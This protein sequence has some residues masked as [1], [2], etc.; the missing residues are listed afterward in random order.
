MSETASDNL[1]GF[2]ASDAWTNMNPEERVSFDYNQS[3]EDL[4]NGDPEYL[5][6]FLNADTDE[7]ER[8]IDVVTEQ[9]KA[10][11]PAAYAT[12]QG[13][14]ELEAEE[15]EALEEEDTGPYAE[16]E[17]LV[18]PD[19]NWAD[20]DEQFRLRRETEA[21]QPV[22]NRFNFD[23]LE[24]VKNGIRVSKRAMSFA[25]PSQPQADGKGYLPESDQRAVHN[26][27]SDKYSWEQIHNA[28]TLDVQEGDPTRADLRKELSAIQPELQE[29]KG[30]FKEYQ[31][32]TNPQEKAY[33]DH[34]RDRFNVPRAPIEDALKEVNHAIS[35]ARNNTGRT[36]KMGDRSP[37]AGFRDVAP[38]TVGESQNEALIKRYG[39]DTP[40]DEVKGELQKYLRILDLQQE[41]KLDSYN[42]ATG[43]REAPVEAFKRADKDLLN[44]L[45][46]IR[47]VRDFPET[48]RV[49]RIL[50]KDFAHIKEFGESNL[51][52]EEESLLMAYLNS[53]EAEQLG[54]HALV[55][56]A[57]IV[58]EMIPYALEFMIAGGMLTGTKAAV[59]KLGFRQAQKKARA[60]IIQ[61]MGED[62]NAALIRTQLRGAAAH[63][64]DDA[65]RA[66]YATMLGAQT[67]LERT[68][69][70]RI[71]LRNIRVEADSA[72]GRL[73]R[74]YTDDEEV[75]DKE[76]GNVWEEFG[77]MWLENFSE[78]GS[79]RLAG[80]AGNFRTQRGIKKAA[81]GRLR[82]EGVS[83]SKTQ[84]VL[85]GFRKRMDQSPMSAKLRGVGKFAAFVAF[86]RGDSALA[87]TMRKAGLGGMV[88][89]Y[90]EESE[91]QMY[92]TLTNLGVGKD[93]K[94]R[95]SIAAKMMDWRYTL[96]PTDGGD[97]TEHL[98]LLGA[99]AVPGAMGAAPG[100]VREIRRDTVKAKEERDIARGKKEIEKAKKRTGSE[101]AG[102]FEAIETAE[103]KE[104]KQL[105]FIEK[106]LKAPLKAAQRKI[107][108]YRKELKTLDKALETK[109]PKGA[110]DT[111]RQQLR[112]VALKRRS[113]ASRALAKAVFDARQA[114]AKADADMKE[115]S[116]DYRKVSDRLYAGLGKMSRKRSQLKN[117]LWYTDR[118]THDAGYDIFVKHLHQVRTVEDVAK[119]ARDLYPLL[120]YGASNPRRMRRASAK[121]MGRLA[122]GLGAMKQGLFGRGDFFHIS[123]IM[124]QTLRDG[125]FSP[126]SFSEMVR[127]AQTA[128]AKV[129]RDR[130]N[131]KVSEDALEELIA[132]AVSKDVGK[133]ITE[134]VIPLLETETR[135]E[136]EAVKANLQD[137]QAGKQITVGG[138]PLKGKLLIKKE[139][140]EKLDPEIQKLVARY[141]IAVD[142]LDSDADV[143]DQSVEYS[144]GRVE[145]EMTDA[146]A[147]AKL[148]EILTELLPEKRLKSMI[149]EIIAYR[150]AHTTL[151][152]SEEKEGEVVERAP[153]ID[154]TPGLFFNVKDQK[155]LKE[156]AGLKGNLIERALLPFAMHKPNGDL[157]VTLGANTADIK[158]EH[159]EQV[160][161]ANGM[162][163]DSIEDAKLLLK[164]F[165]RTLRT[166]SKMLEASD[167]KHITVPDS[168][169][170]FLNPD[171][172]RIEV[173]SILQS[174][175]LILESE[176]AE[177]T[178]LKFFMEFLSSVFTIMMMSKTGDQ[179][180][181][182]RKDLDEYLE[183][184]RNMAAFEVMSVLLKHPL[185]SASFQQLLHSASVKFFPETAWSKMMPPGWKAPD[186][187]TVK[188]L[189]GRSFS[190]EAIEQWEKYM[191]LYD[192]PD[193]EVGMALELLEG[194]PVQVAEEPD[195]E[196]EEKAMEAAAKEA[197]VD[198][199]G[200]DALMT[201]EYM[202]N[203]RLTDSSFTVPPGGS[204]KKGHLA[205]L[206]RSIDSD[207]VKE[208][209]NR[210][211][212]EALIAK[213]E[214]EEKA[215]DAEEIVG[216]GKPVRK[217]RKAHRR[218]KISQ[219]FARVTKLFPSLDGSFS[220][221]G[222]AYAASPLDLLKIINTTEGVETAD[223]AS[224][225]PVERDRAIP[226]AWK[227]TN[228]DLKRKGGVFGATIRTS[229]LWMA[230]QFIAGNRYLGT[231]LRYSDEFAKLFGYEELETLDL[232]L[233]RLQVLRKVSQDL[234]DSMPKELQALGIRQYKDFEKQ[235]TQSGE[236]GPTFG[237]E[238]EEAPLEDLNIEGVDTDA[239]SGDID[240]G[241]LA[242]LDLDTL[243]S[244]AAAGLTD[245][246]R[247]TV[248]KIK[249]V[250]RAYA[251]GFL[252]K[253]YSDESL[254][255]KQ[256]EEMVRGYITQLRSKLP[257]DKIRAI[258]EVGF[259]ELFGWTLK[260]PTRDVH[261]K[262]AMRYVVNEVKVFAYE[263]GI[264]NSVDAED[265]RADEETAQVDEETNRTREAAVMLE[266]NE[267]WMTET[268]ALL[269]NFK[270]KKHVA[271]PM[272]L[273]AINS[274]TQI[275]VLFKAAREI[276][277][278]HLEAGT[279]G[280][281]AMEKE[282]DAEFGRYMRSPKL[283]KAEEF[284]IRE[285]R[286]H[287][288]R[289][290]AFSFSD[291]LDLYNRFNGVEARPIGWMDFVRSSSYDFD[292]QSGERTQ[293]WGDP[294]VEATA[295]SAKM[296]M[297]MVR[298][299][300]TIL[301]DALSTKDSARDFLSLIVEIDKT[302]D[303]GADYQTSVYAFWS[304]LLGVPADILE[305]ADL[306]EQNRRSKRKKAPVSPL[307]WIL[308]RA[309]ST[310]KEKG[311]RE[312][313]KEIG[314]TAI[315][316][317]ALNQLEEVETADL[318][319]WLQRLYLDFTA[320]G[321]VSERTNR[322]NGISTIEQISN[323]MPVSQNPLEIRGARGQRIPNL[324]PMNAFYRAIGKAREA[325][326]AQNPNSMLWDSLQIE[327][328]REMRRAGRSLSGFK[329]KAVEP[330]DVHP[331]DF[332]RGVY[333]FWLSQEGQGFYRV[334]VGAFGDKKA[335][336]FVNMPRVD[337]L[338]EAVA[339]YDKIQGSLTP[340]EKGL[341]W[342]S[343]SDLMAKGKAAGYNGNGLVFLLND[344]A[345]RI[346]LNKQIHGDLGRFVAP[347]TEAEVKAQTLTQRVA[348]ATK[349]RTALVKRSG[350]MLSGGVTMSK[351][352]WGQEYFNAVTINDPKHLVSALSASLGEAFTSQDQKEIQRLMQAAEDATDGF[353]LIMPET[354]ARMQWAFGP[355]ITNSE[356]HGPL[357]IMKAIHAGAELNKFGAGVLTEEFAT[358]YEDGAFKILWEA[359][360]AHN[361]KAKD[362]ANELEPIDMIFFGSTDK[363][364][365][366]K[367]FDLYDTTEVR[368]F[369]PHADVTLDKD[370]T[371]PT[372]KVQQIDLDDFYWLL[373]AGHHTKPEARP[374]A[375]QV[376]PII[377]EF[378]GL[379]DSFLDLQVAHMVEEAEKAGELI[380]PAK[381]IRADSH[382][383]AP[384]IQSGILDPYSPLVR[385][386]VV[387]QQIKHLN[388]AL[389]LKADVT[390]LVEQP[391]A[392]P[393]FRLPD[394]QLVV[395]SKDA[396]KVWRK[397]ASSEDG[398]AVR[399]SRVDANVDGVRQTHALNGQGGVSARTVDSALKFMLRR[400]VFPLVLD[401][402]VI[403]EHVLKSKEMMARLYKDPK[404]TYKSLGVIPR[405][406]ELEFDESGYIQIPGAPLLIQRVP[407]DN[408]YSLSMVRL[409]QNVPGGANVIRTSFDRQI[410]TGSDFD[411]DK[412]FVMSM[413]RFT[414]KDGSVGKLDLRAD[415]RW[416]NYNRFLLKM[417]ATYEDQAN[418]ERITNSL[419][420]DKWS[421]F[422]NQR[423]Q[424][425]E[426]SKEYLASL[427][428]SPATLAGAYDA[429]QA[430]SIG[431]RGLSFVASGMYGANLMAYAKFG[432][433]RNMDVPIGDRI[434]KVNRKPG[435]VT[436]FRP[437]KD[438]LGT[439]LNKHA[440]HANIQ[441][442]D[443]IGGN[444][445]TSSLFV[446]LLY[447]NAD[448]TTEAEVDAYIEDIAELFGTEE[449]QIWSELQREQNR[450]ATGTR[451]QSALKDE[452]FKRMG[453]IRTTDEMKTSTD[454]WFNVI[455]MSQEFA[456]VMQ[457][458][459]GYLR[460][461]ATPSEFDR[462]DQ[463]IK[464]VLRGYN[465]FERLDKDGMLEVSRSPRML[466]DGKPVPASAD[467]YSLTGVPKVFH[468]TLLA[469]RIAK[470]SV[471]SR[472]PKEQGALNQLSHQV[473]DPV[474]VKDKD[475]EFKLEFMP[476]GEKSTRAY[477][478]A[479]AQYTILRTLINA[480]PT[481]LDV[482]R[483]PYH[484]VSIAYRLV[485]RLGQLFEEQPGNPFLT[486]A[487][488]WAADAE[489][490]LVEVLPGFA[491]A[492]LPAQEEAKIH[493][494]FSA[495]PDDVKLELLTYAIARFGVQTHTGNSSFLRWVDPAY[496]LAWSNAI[497]NT[498][499][500]LADPRY[501]LSA[502]ELATILPS[503]KTAAKEGRAVSMLVPQESTISTGDV[504]F[505][506]SVFDT[507]K[508]A[509]EEYA[510]T[511]RITLPV[512][513]PGLELFKSDDAKHLL[514]IH[515]YDFEGSDY[516]KEMYEQ[517]SQ[518]LKDYAEDSQQ[519]GEE[520]FGAETEY[521]DPIAGPTLTTYLY[522]ESADAVFRRYGVDGTLEE[523]I[524]QSM[525]EQ[526]EKGSEEELLITELY[527]PQPVV[528]AD[529][530]P[531][532]ML[533]AA[534]ASYGEKPDR[535]GMTKAD[536]DLY[537]EARAKALTGRKAVS[538]AVFDAVV[539]ENKVPSPNQR[540]MIRE[541]NA[542]LARV[543]TGI[544]TLEDVEVARRVVDYALKGKN[545]KL[546]QIRES[547]HAYLDY[548]DQIPAMKLAIRKGNAAMKAREEYKIAVEKQEIAG[549][550]LELFDGLVETVRKKAQSGDLTISDA[551]VQ[552]SA[553]AA[554]IVERDFEQTGSYINK[555]AHNILLKGSR[556]VA[557]FLAEQSGHS[558]RQRD[559]VGARDPAKNRAL[560]LKDN[561]GELLLKA[562]TVIREAGI[563]TMADLKAFGPNLYLF[564]YEDIQ[565]IPGTDTYMVPENKRVSVVEIVEQYEKHRK[566]HSELAEWT[567]VLVDMAR[568]SQQ[569]REDLN[570][571]LGYTWLPNLPGHVF[572]VYDKGPKAGKREG[573]LSF[574]AG[575]GRRHP[576]MRDYK[577]V[578]SHA[579]FA[580]QTWDSTELYD[581]WLRSVSQAV[582]SRMVMQS[583]VSMEDPHGL[584]PVILGLEESLSEH[585]IPMLRRK[586]GFKM[587]RQVTNLLNKEYDYKLKV[588]QI[589]PTGDP[590]VQ[591]DRIATQ[592]ES[593]LHEL[594]YRKR[595]R[596]TF[597][598]DVKYVLAQRGPVSAVITH[599][600][601]GGFSE[602]YR[603][604]KEETEGNM[605]ALT[606]EASMWGTLD[607][608]KK[609][610][611]AIKM[612]N[613]G[614]SAFHHIALLE[615]F[616]ADEGIRPLKT[617]FA[618]ITAVIMM[619]DG[620]KTFK[621]MHTDTA[622]VAKWAARG[623]DISTIPIDVNLNLIDRAF[624]GLGTFLRKSRWLGIPSLG[625]TNLMGMG[626]LGAGNLKKRFDNFLWHGMVPVMKL[627]MADRLYEK[628]RT[629]PEM[630]HLNNEQ[631]GN[632]VAAYVNDALGGQEWEQYLF[633][634]PMIRDWANLIAFAPDW[635]ISA[636]NVSGLTSVMGEAF[637]VKVRQ[638]YTNDPSGFLNSPLIQ[639][640]L[641]KYWPGFIMNVLVMWPMTLQAIVFAASGGDDENDH[642]WMWENEGE[643]PWKEKNFLGMTYY[644]PN[645][646]SEKM[647]ADI[648]PAL[649]V[650]ARWRG[651]E[652]DWTKQRRVYLSF[653]KQAKE[654]IS[655]LM[656]PGETA[657]SKS[658]TL[659]RM[660]VTAATGAK[661]YPF[662]E[663]V[664]R[665][666]EGQMTTEL[667]KMLLPFSASGLF[668]VDKNI[669]LGLRFFAPV[670]RG[671]SAWA[672]SKNLGE[673]YVDMV[674]GT[675]NFTRMDWVERM[676][677]MDELERN[678][679]AT[680]R[681]NNISELKVVKSS[682]TNARYHLNATMWD[683]MM[684]GDSPKNRERLLDALT[685][686]LFLESNDKQAQANLKQLINRR[687][688][689]EKYSEE[690]RERAKSLASSREFAKLVNRATKEARVRYGRRGRLDL[691]EYQGEE[692]DAP[693]NYRF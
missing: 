162:F 417:V 591:V 607:F 370:F 204:F 245:K 233:A 627:T 432:F 372:E 115:V 133:A 10:A 201:K 36:Q 111:R 684:K 685:G 93:E 156:A 503:L 395:P 184:P 181:Q 489:M 376:A 613:V 63:L 325:E 341:Y 457:A 145:A 38:L 109:L 565:Q 531:P 644:V 403:P 4:R 582:Q 598:R 671:K 281:E 425:K 72:D 440:D 498:E 227:S 68:E 524:E 523:F 650:I 151:V 474:A 2:Y 628:L 638:M 29:Q 256:L 574:E 30:I 427:E 144:M 416:G 668:D 645:I 49:G 26:L 686:I 669:P 501:R 539:G 357:K 536:Y 615:S 480:S 535:F 15:P 287:S 24:D 691:D 74:S 185:P 352:L 429:Y 623:M 17:R 487:I 176:E 141:S 187:A 316:Q 475:G 231:K 353:A 205:V 318:R 504:G 658:S 610:T 305:Q 654:V 315:A 127:I 322:G 165:Q 198:F 6:Q 327:S 324:N 586:E 349:A 619:A 435:V 444:E 69:A 228:K 476:S 546:V 272:F 467:V 354:M 415:K 606:I 313:V 253:A 363:K 518:R 603:R 624:S 592:F 169:F 265:T 675:G 328:V 355:A 254:T 450:M 61:E 656:N 346:A 107:A 262:L 664:W 393:T 229:G 208:N 660:A 77:A 348:R 53:K 21:S 296:S 308:G 483:A 214:A 87:R 317:R 618:P 590:W 381:T 131:A 593:Q 167:K 58:G 446:F 640:R 493:A 230:A 438:A 636:L 600:G 401:M 218:L 240:F 76:A 40:L 511:G 193:Y 293:T 300:S 399:L 495:L 442:I 350:S 276:E 469:Y 525:T 108:R 602:A 630:A 431:Q 200:F 534:A 211:A 486:K 481:L 463:T 85:E 528:E 542:R 116:K 34:T 273:D 1:G 19:K 3:Y 409:H 626:I 620:Y 367:A 31:G 237:L 356:E 541:L 422:I 319:N 558:R 333:E 540:K 59:G 433:R 42:I 171:K 612:I 110:E 383:W 90:L 631:I 212:I 172:K 428:S 307:T 310:Y 168:E 99:F 510:R 166:F 447:A 216:S 298:S 609:V 533:S 104:E 288:Q 452:W 573:M 282:L 478:E 150:R 369:Q 649:R 506:A 16:F 41:A 337:T 418:F 359:V 508:K 164:E 312:V 583:L 667:G 105:S 244:A 119:A 219:V 538:D 366:G 689:S 65:L 556:A 634:S 347:M 577:S 146:E 213:Y 263:R 672:L 491:Q 579:G 91:N 94:D 553:A 79:E 402:F 514:A 88:F 423:K 516:T 182:S 374:F 267:R 330:R 386:F 224:L 622:S 238:G 629:M 364:K 522:K 343:A 345:N 56:G 46:V 545:Q 45:P 351:E 268:Q 361:E 559:M 241:D 456:E 153:L 283:T 360:Q 557:Q 635:T 202:F 530:I 210:E 420:V 424:E 137:F 51:T 680:A 589:D 183:N 257:D 5:E 419:E 39:A 515:W 485:E 67:T 406:W 633:M 594:G 585:K 550:Q 653:G 551:E 124:S 50:Q 9:R 437:V 251:L 27:L 23:S 28:Y 252:K 362:P 460:I 578:M 426:S 665:V 616:V 55:K 274:S 250:G 114:R 35:A 314:W 291:L 532:T 334:W 220:Y 368:A 342:E 382:V 455:E 614:F 123:D 190:V 329:Q 117:K 304:H 666:A 246:Q 96:D 320:Q 179:Q 261:R 549:E 566:K 570:A 81:A 465:I 258:A 121:L 575:V 472:L 7:Q 567:D 149:Q 375:V 673:E 37:L 197:N 120:R 225:N 13:S 235:L 71:Q 552:F 129:R 142:K 52:T 587:L 239:D 688:T 441:H 527:G 43:R 617:L 400:E 520:V 490:A 284:M 332:M 632:D 378:P 411:I 458:M 289:G 160:F 647:K 290:N 584:P 643:P 499:A 186:N 102:A 459:R 398:T 299:L 266:A 502:E 140:W 236:I 436:D 340:Q 143:Y 134:G 180:S 206:K 275:P 385:E 651:Q 249:G 292:P 448:L 86:G 453:K 157:I 652:I 112:K 25:Y 454:I 692:Q 561:P 434:I 248:D 555:K 537:Y 396:S 221:K 405:T 380:D 413:R 391:I 597:G 404:G 519:E 338:E 505:D 152:P 78:S 482:K 408:N 412:R 32:K 484:H 479:I 323:A 344:A 192:E 122:P 462:K 693:I 136:A 339:Y 529:P 270:F 103:A 513:L 678:T 147:Q 189:T 670:T 544:D 139:K 543:K 421:D 269:R 326:L 226:P 12:P 336:H 477:R 195:A 390:Q 439:V 18:D 66:T 496:V 445:F 260:A 191:N 303:K 232:Q 464:S 471:F 373:S 595:T 73:L 407:S 659:S 64:G 84:R 177:A 188:L 286:D 681:A 173:A 54:Q 674:Q 280:S 82:A 255:N 203:D 306:E 285:I 500:K 113:I 161:M 599:I 661:G 101:D 365:S 560:R 294:K 154:I 331:E 297:S 301:S 389:R 683:L 209:G 497:A 646:K 468:P 581:L 526:Y 677:K 199:L 494:G 126:M 492:T 159:I 278:R 488:T 271:L 639:H 174:I 128:E 601:T 379:L 207:F 222:R 97:L 170:G 80:I 57:G 430:N 242:D 321:F 637:G 547:L 466:F 569:A 215:P 641:R 20:D 98:T 247:E 135:E 44:Y 302:R 568:T 132:T 196:A 451:S 690:D 130:K 621:E 387:F 158:E 662:G 410:K 22:D 11:F 194:K 548:R 512:E 461:P 384:L 175:D 657:Y 62:A 95:R 163:S 358:Q 48:R 309:R 521:D 259:Y 83:P 588:P 277:K 563:Y 625:A 394:Y 223:A 679:L 473:F 676:Q 663:N 155:A 295:A 70:K 89:E 604:A 576:K 596:H 60:K 234:F 33:S 414:E 397:A 138:K 279:F 682:R 562:I 8:V 75:Y 47:D 571:M 178:Q 118:K 655:W 642:M 92:I 377:A 125:Q 554:A 371:F 564:E 148:E 100:M 611:Q 449:I 580:P 509:L 243:L 388:K 470:D 264:I 687:V 507:V 517:D 217:P 605:L 311:G 14:E 572:H 106:T 443:K 392:A 608:F 335:L 648:T